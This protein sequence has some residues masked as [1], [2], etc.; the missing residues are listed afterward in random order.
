MCFTQHSSRKRRRPSLIP[1]GRNVQLQEKSMETPANYSWN[2]RYLTF[3][4]WKKSITEM[5]WLAPLSCLS[6][7]MAKTLH[8]KYISRWQT[9]TQQSQIPPAPKTYRNHLSNHKTHTP[10][11]WRRSLFWLVWTCFRG[12]CVMQW[13]GTHTQRF[14]FSLFK[15]KSL[16]PPR[17]PLPCMPPRP[18]RS[19]TTACGVALGVGK[20]SLEC[21]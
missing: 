4:L 2:I 9:I 19:P 16:F 5:Q 11:T 12:I 18:V 13:A 21:L 7:H 14:S 1:Q 20:T 8:S 15:S 6:V 17:P 10:L 3:T